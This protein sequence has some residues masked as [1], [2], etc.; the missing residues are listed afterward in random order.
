MRSISYFI[1]AYIAL[2]LQ[3]GLGE[4][5]WMRGA[6]PNLPLLAVIFIAV[7]A[8]REAA[9]LGAFGIGVMQDM[10]TLHPLGLYAL[11]YSVVAMFVVSTQELVY[12]E[13]PLTHFS[14]AL[15]S[16]LLTAAVVLI[17]GWIRPIAPAIPGVLP[18][19]RM[20]AGALFSSAIYTA[21]AAPFVLWFLQRIRKAFAF[22]P[23]RR[24]HA[25]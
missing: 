9:L 16:G 6:G 7:N 8:S 22:T 17:H 25:W 13:H 12:R 3:I 21:I 15:V 24:G 2:G 10:T 11:A 14:L 19:A 4:V 5:S 20:P 1:L 23:Q 18:A